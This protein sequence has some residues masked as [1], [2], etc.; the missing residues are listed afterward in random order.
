M[1][2]GTRMFPTIPELITAAASTVFLDDA[3][4]KLLSEIITSTFRVIAPPQ[5]SQWDPFSSREIHSL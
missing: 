1:T 3:N 5:H 4:G 2:S